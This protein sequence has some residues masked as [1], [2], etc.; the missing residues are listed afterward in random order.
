MTA[1]G[2][3]YKV[4]EDVAESKDVTSRYPEKKADLIRLYDELTKDLPDA[5]RE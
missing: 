4:S 5:V 1:E 3:L 2:E